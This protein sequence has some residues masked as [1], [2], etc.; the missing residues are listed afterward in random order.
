MNAVTVIEAA[1]LSSPLDTWIANGRALAERRRDVDWEIADW[2]SEGREAGFIT[3][4]GFDFLADNL[5][6]GPAKLKI[7][8]KAAAIPAHLRDTSLTVE[9]HAV[10]AKL[11]KDDQ[12]NLLNQASR[13]HWKVQDL[14]EAVTQRRYEAGELFDDEDIESTLCTLIVRAWNRATPAAR[15][16]FMDLAKVA[17]L[18]I[19]DE[20]EANDAED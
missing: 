20:D 2:M 10:V 5:G 19:I 1:N 9:H 7:I 4:A 11:P 6:I 17:K 14:R 16:S 13:E 12:L 3:Q 15:Q 8:S 18:G